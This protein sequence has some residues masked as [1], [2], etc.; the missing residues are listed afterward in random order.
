[1]YIWLVHSTHVLYKVEVS[2]PKLCLLHLMADL[3]YLVQR[4]DWVTQ[5]LVQMTAQEGLSN[6]QKMPQ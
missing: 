3:G 5:G 4:S 1:M 6:G 2:V